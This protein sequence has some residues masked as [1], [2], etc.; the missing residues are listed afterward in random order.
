MNKTIAQRISE[1]KQ[2]IA[3]CI[4]S[5]NTT[6]MAKA[7]LELNQWLQEMP[8]GSRFDAGTV[9]ES[10]SP[11]ELVFNTA[12][13][14]MNDNGMYTGWTHHRVIARAVFG[15]FTVNVTGREQRG[16]KSNN[17]KEY[18]G[19]VFYHWLSTELKDT[20]P[21]Q[22]QRDEKTNTTKAP[23]TLEYDPSKKKQKQIGRDKPVIEYKG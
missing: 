1:L 7:E 9:L 2:Q 12:F 4:D 19:E 16:N 3:N 8:S 6:W 20:R 22:L 17:I 5:G 21:K 13:H 11:Q 18:I 14:H 10:A 15:E 23:L